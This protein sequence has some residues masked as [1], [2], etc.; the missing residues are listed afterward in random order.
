MAALAHERVSKD[1]VRCDEP[2]LRAPRCRVLFAPHEVGGQ[3]ALIANAMARRG[4][5]A[6]S[7]SYE[8]QCAALLKCDRS[9][10]IDHAE[11]QF[12]ALAKKFAF[13]CKAVRSFD[14]FH[15]FF[16]R[17]LLNRGIDLR[18]LR[19][20]QKGI[21]VHFRGND[22]INGDYHHYQ[23]KQLIGQCGAATCLQR[24]W[25]QKMVQ[26]W[27][28]WANRMLVSSPHLLSAVPD[29]TIVP[30][31]IDLEHW[32]ASAKIDPGDVIRIAHAPTSRMI[33]GTDFVVAA[34]ESLKNKGLPVELDLIE[35]IDPAAVPGRMATADIGV[36]QLVIGWYGNVSIQFMA[37]GKPVICYID[38]ELLHHRPDMPIVSAT[39][40]TITAELE[41]LVVDAQ[42]RRTLGEAG[43]RYVEKWHDV[44]RIV[45]QLLGIY[46][47]VLN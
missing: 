41:R 35:S 11:W 34:V 7:V 3:M 15:F 23:R 46:A 33:K 27:R 37:L 28:R 32:R 44:N 16:G 40:A 8:R 29:A 14:V 13:A 43:R 1:A 10:N 45:D 47:E 39:P 4:L 36:D 30:Q 17:S 12:R 6:T 5:Q 2:L 9:L 20:M 24:P 25:Q 38:P 21:V 31:A 26:R 18:W 19:R 42:L 22:I